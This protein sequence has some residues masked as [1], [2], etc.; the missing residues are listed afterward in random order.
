MRAYFSRYKR[1]IF[2]SLFVIAIAAAYL[3][4]RVKIHQNYFVVRLGTF[5]KFIE[6][7]GEILGK[8]A[9]NITLSDIFKDPDIQV[10]DLKIK[11]MVPEG[12][13][14]K[15]GDWVASLDQININQRIQMNRE[16]LDL[17]EAN[18]KDAKID[19]A[20]DL[21]LL[22]QAIVEQ[23][24]E[25]EYFDIDLKQSQYES[26]S[27][28]RRMK[29]AYHQKNRQIER[30][31]RNYE[32][33]KMDLGNQMK[34]EEIGYNYH[35]KVD[36]KLQMALAATHITAPD[37]GM[38]IYTRTRGNRKI[39]IGD[40][41][42]PWKPVIAT[43]PD[44][45][46]LVSETYVEEIDIAKINVNDSVITTVD[47]LPGRQFTGKIRTIANIGQQLQGFDSRVFSVTIELDGPNQ[48]LLPGMTSSNRI[49][50][51]RIPN[52]LLI[53]RKCLY[54]GE[55]IFFVYVKKEGR[56][57]KKRVKP[58]YENDEMVMIEKGLE[59]KDRILLSPPE[60]ADGIEFVEL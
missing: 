23:V 53:P 35:K 17:R 10:W 42:G 51:E 21:S 7:K 34:R 5:E 6:T 30:L 33:Q 3:F 19:T 4:S 28:Q 40:E 36:A 60:N 46:V 12:T 37:A 26:P 59:V 32:L 22:R 14:V 16:A 11:D 39:R 48:K 27:Y 38:V 55:N 8:N 20:V 43:L 1:W 44:L 18:L 25:L 45:T 31:K 9:I 2:F 15:K 52:Q 13:I 29:A 50:L 56:I 58:G 24:A 54:S 41:V 49:T 47:A 57:W